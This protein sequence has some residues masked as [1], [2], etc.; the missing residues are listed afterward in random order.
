M[1]LT[2]DGMSLP[3]QQIAL[4]IRDGVPVGYLRPD[5]PA[6]QAVFIDI[7]HPAALCCLALAQG[8]RP[9]IST[10]SPI[11]TSII[12]EYADHVSGERDNKVLGW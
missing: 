4:D 2:G 5:S 7:G 1:K 6:T 12:M 3:P 10:C 8:S 11:T 9:T